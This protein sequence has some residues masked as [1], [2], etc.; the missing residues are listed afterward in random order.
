MLTNRLPILPVLSVFVFLSAACASAPTATPVPTA[1]FASTAT[2]LPTANPTAT[3]TATST[4]TST[5][6]VTPLPTNTPTPTATSTQSPTPTATPQPQV[7][8]KEMTG[9]YAGP[10]TLMYDT[11]AVLP[12]DT[13]V[14]PLGIYVDY[15]K[16]ETEINGTVKNGFIPTALLD[17]P[18]V[19]IP[20][21]N[22]D[23]APGL[24]TQVFGPD[25]LGT[26]QNS[27][28]YSSSIVLN[29]EIIADTATQL[30]LKLRID[31][32]N[33][34]QSP[35]DF[36]ASIVLSNDQ[37]SANRRGLVLYYQ[38][39]RW[40]MQVGIADRVRGL[41]EL[42][43]DVDNST[44]FSLWIS[45]DGKT[46]K[47][48]TPDGKVQ[49]LPLPDSL[50]VGG[51][52]LR[53]FVGV[54]PGFSLKISNLTL[55]WLPNGKYTVFDTTPATSEPALVKMP[56]SDKTGNDAY[57]DFAKVTPEQ[58]WQ[59]A[60]DMW[61]W[62]TYDHRL[63]DPR[64]AYYSEQFRND[65]GD[66]FNPLGLLVGRQMKGSEVPNYYKERPVWGMYKYGPTGGGYTELPDISIY[67]LEVV[68]VSGK[69][70]KV[71]GRE[72]FQVRFKDKNGK[73][74][75]VYLAI[76]SP[77]IISLATAPSFNAPFPDREYAPA[78]EFAEV[79]N[80]ID[81]KMF[82]KGILLGLKVPKDTKDLADI[83]GRNLA[84]ASSRGIIFYIT[85]YEP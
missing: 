59:L 2:A 26:Y 52:N 40:N 50:Y 6:T 46:V 58:T 27:S 81:S 35:N 13:K 66:P 7:H 37:D 54:S 53:A 82:K 63:S 75:N 65:H 70:E 34:R 45:Q 17:R 4:L 49:S 14:T 76:D 56:W 41:G 16:V 25:N 1:T 15:V 55:R 47:V 24:I 77:V 42:P 44:E 11:V 57:F 74:G 21:L 23:Q 28:S 61:K 62:Y 18:G 3:A 38:N 79:A 32:I 73:E 78:N 85:P 64:F 5:P 22:P 83:V 51:S 48:T 9:L 71:S 19:N 8:V 84:L 72:T 43:T 10:D 80:R 67:N 30:D 68:A 31:T 20:N 33:S 39:K 36:R 12:K 29:T 60:R 69:I